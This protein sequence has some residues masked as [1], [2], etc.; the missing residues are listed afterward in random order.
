MA[1]SAANNGG[2]KLWKDLAILNIILLQSIKEVLGNQAL[3][4]N[5]Y[6]L[7]TGLKISDSF[8]RSKTSNNV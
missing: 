6:V 2:S 1:T 4:T 5:A 3:K 7:T 8:A